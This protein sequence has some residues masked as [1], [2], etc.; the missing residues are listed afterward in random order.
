MTERG[1]SGPRLVLTAA[2]FVAAL[3]LR[4]WTRFGLNRSP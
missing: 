1:L 3:G 2:A 4:L